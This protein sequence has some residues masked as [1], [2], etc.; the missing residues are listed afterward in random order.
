MSLVPLAS[1]VPANP[2]ILL[3]DDHSDLRRT[4][5]AMLAKH[6][7]PVSFIEARDGAHALQILVIAS[8][9]ITLVISDLNMPIVNGEAL[10]KIMKDRYPRLFRHFILITASGSPSDFFLEHEIPVVSK[11]ENDHLRNTVD[12]MLL[13][14]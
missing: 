4:C 3:V 10:A 7:G 5:R 14:D 1:A 12:R 13:R 8:K 6:L 9:D 11:F 2:L